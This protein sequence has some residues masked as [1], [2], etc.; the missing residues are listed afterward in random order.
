M[1][2]SSGVKLGDLDDFLSLSEDCVK[3]LIEAASGGGAFKLDAS[4]TESKARP[5]AEAVQVQKPNLIKS[6]AS[7][8]DP[9]AQIG[10][11]TLSDCLACSGCVTSAETVLLQEQSGEEFLKRSATSPVTVVT[12]TAQ[13]CASLA[14]AAESRSGASMLLLMQKLAGALQRL[15]ATYVLDGSAAEAI[16]LLEGKAEFVQ[17]FVEGQKGA[18]GKA[19]SNNSSSSLPLLTSH[20]PG[21]TCYAEKVVDPVVMPHLA[22]L[23]PAQQIQGRLVKTCLLEAHNRRRLH[24][25]WRARSPLFA[26]ECAWWL[27]KVTPADAEGCKPLMPGD[28]YHVSVQPCFDRK[29]EAA[30]PK[31]Q[32]DEG[33][34]EVDTVLTTTELLDLVMNPSAPTGE[35]EEAPTPQAVAAEALAALPLLPLGSEVLTDLLLQDLKTARPGRLLPTAVAGNGGSGGFAEHVFREAARELFQ[36]E[37][38]A[39]LEFRTKQNED[40]REVTLEDPKSKKVLLR[41]LAAYGFRNIQNAIK[42][43]TKPSSGDE[44]VH[45]V[46]IMACPGGCLNGGGQIPEPKRKGPEPAGA[47][48]AGSTQP[49]RRERLSE[50]EATFHSGEGIVVTPPAEHPLL[51]E[52]YRY[53]AVRAAAGQKGVKAAGLAGEGLQSLVGS[54]GVKAW[55]AAD[56]KSLKVDE[57]GNAVLSSSVLKW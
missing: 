7:K 22:P 28:I 16:A 18:R 36:I 27:R 37:V 23:R 26:A 47:A 12:I 3:P 17:R 45:F 20:C 40:M 10:Q 29:I 14:V 35:G 33:E 38:S 34:R 41:F 30:R 50:L 2:F 44:A 13:A 48:D 46:E 56:W 25:W 5:V 15:G 55:L 1:G 57:S 42:R 8:D 43:I 39:P 9:K 19:K 6:K 4:I 54:A 52:I 24:R 51:P 11:V 49:R 32:L 21:W 31:F 53:M